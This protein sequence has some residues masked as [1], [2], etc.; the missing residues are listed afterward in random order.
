MKTSSVA[1]SLEIDKYD[2]D[3]VP[4]SASDKE[5]EEELQKSIKHCYQASIFLDDKQNRILEKG[6][7]GLILLR[8]EY[9]SKD[10]IDPDRELSGVEE[11]ANEDIEKTLEMLREA[12]NEP[13]KFN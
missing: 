12:I 9:K 7:A 10:E 6:M 1:H 3:I 11:Q 8:S 2:T 5:L 13:S 4:V